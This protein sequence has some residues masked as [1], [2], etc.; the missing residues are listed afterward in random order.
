MIKKNKKPRD[1]SY[2]QGYKLIEEHGMDIVRETWKRV[3][4]YEA[5]RQLGASPYV[6][7]H[8]SNKY[9]WKRPAE[10]CQNIVL[11]VQRGILDPANYQHLD[12]SNVEITNK[13][14]IGGSHE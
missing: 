13:K 11:G 4:M 9:G 8:L 1:V 7:R 5:G 2:S 10:N 3:G 14:E 12:W 6:L